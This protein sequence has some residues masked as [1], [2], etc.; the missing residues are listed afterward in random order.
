VV[1]WFTS[2]GRLPDLG[3]SSSFAPSFFISG[4][5]GERFTS[6]YLLMACGLGSYD[7]R[8]ECQCASYRH[9]LVAVITHLSVGIDRLPR[10]FA[11]RLRD[12][13]MLRKR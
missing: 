7:V 6:L 10:L 2:S 3:V 9:Q 5:V 12:G 13:R 8:T 4:T 1:R 11:L